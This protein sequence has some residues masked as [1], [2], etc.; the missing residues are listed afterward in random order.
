MIWYLLLYA[1]CCIAIFLLVKTNFSEIKTWQKFLMVLFSPL[2]IVIFVLIFLCIIPKHI[3]ENGFKNFFP[4]RKGKAYP[5]NKSDFRGWSKDTILDGDKKVSIDEFNKAH[6]TS[7]T[8]DD[9]YGRGFMDSMTPE[10]VYECKTYI[11][12]KFGLE[13]NMPNYIYK[14]AAIAFAK[15]FISGDV[16][17]ISTFLTE[18]THLVLFKREEIIGKKKIAEYFHKWINSAK[19]VNIQTRV[20]VEWNVNQC[21]PVV[22]VSPKGYNKMVLIFIFKDGLLD[23]LTFG[24]RSIQGK[25]VHFHDLDTP[26]F[27]LEYMSQFIA[28]DAASE[29]LHLNCPTCGTDS[30]LLDW[31]KFQMNLGSVGYSGNVSVCDDCKR[32]VEYQPDTRYRLDDTN[33][34]A[35]S[36]PK[37]ETFTPFVP[38]LLG[39]YTLETYDDNMD[40]YDETTLQFKGED[41]LQAYKMFGDVEDANNYGVYLTNS[42]NSEKAIEIFTEAAEHG[43]Q[44]A[45][46][47]VFTV[48]WANEGNYKKAVEWLKY[49]AGSPSPSIKC[50]WNLAVLYYFGNNLPNNP[51]FKDTIKAKDL[52]SRIKDLSLDGLDR[53][54]QRIIV[55]ARKF[56][57]L[58]DVINDFSVAGIQI[59][60]IIT[61]S[62]VKTEGLKD[63][64]EFFYRAKALKTK[65]GWKLGLRL[66][67]DNT[68]DIGDESEFFLYNDK[69]EQ[70]KIDSGGILVQ[71]TA[72]GAWQYYLLMT[73]PT[74]MP[75]VWH[76]EYICRTF[77]FNVE[78]LSKIEPIKDYDFTILN[79]DGLLLPKV[80][81]APDGKSA[82]VYCTFFND[83]EGLVREHV[84]ITFNSDGSASIGKAQTFAF[85]PYD[86][87]ICL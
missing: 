66:A 54:Y 31:Y 70:R 67:D 7:L 74:I 46:L 13:P 20:T 85:Y 47:N 60:H 33:I 71:P 56:Y 11:P 59:H 63:K 61:K 75:V 23:Q 9:V 83:W 8:L 39:L 25:W 14:S 76:G 48:Y 79:K 65:A 78:D 64:S 87:G 19:E 17:E 62:I 50:I 35:F 30:L 82:D 2:V 21:R 86:C 84:K 37:S 51:L 55:D 45:M 73:S 72:M 36:L 10:E 18:N 32:V 3:K 42:G 57:D 81:L 12:G 52:L 69:G 58:V 44:N 38:R 34:P 1:L 27:S 77:I 49:V 6:N 80:E 28:D 40:S 16:D 22:Y 4:H 29:E 43:C 41:F 68:S 5:L 15:A 24:P 53:D 26:T